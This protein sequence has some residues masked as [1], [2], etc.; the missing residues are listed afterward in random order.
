MLDQA[1]IAAIAAVVFFTALGVPRLWDRDEPRNAGCAAEML[2]RHDW[3]VPVFNAELRAHKPVLLYW[4]MMSAYATFGVTE[5]AARFWSALLGVGTALV[6]YHVGRR[7]FDE[8]VGLW[9]AVVLATTLMFGVAAR[10]ATPDSALIFFTTLAMA[11]YVFGTFPPR[12]TEADAASDTPANDVR[13]WYP[14]RWSVVALIYA[15]MGIAVLAKGPVGLVLPTASI[16]MFLLIMRLPGTREKKRWLGSSA[17]SPREAIRD[18]LGNMRAWCACVRNPKS[19]AR[20]PKQIPNSNERKPKQAALRADRVFTRRGPGFGHSSFRFLN[21][22]RISDFEI[23]I[24]LRLCRVRWV[25]YVLA[26][27]RPFAPLH[28]L[29]TCWFMRPITALAAALAVALPWYLWV[30]LRTGGAWIEEFF[31]VHNVGRAAQAMEGHDGPFF[32]YLIAICVGFFPWSIFFGPTLI[33]AAR[34]IRADHPWKPGLILLVCW[35]G[36]YVGLFSLARTKLPNYI[37]P[38]YPA[39][40]LLTGSFLYR[41]RRQPAWSPALLPKLS[42]AI[43]VLV[44]LGM[45][46]GLPLAAHLYLP[47]EEWLGLIALVPLVGGIVAL[48]LQARAKPGPVVTAVAV[49]SVLFATALVG[50]VPVRV[51]RHRTDHALLDAI[52]ARGDAPRIAALG[53]LEPSWVFYGRQPITELRR[54]DVTAAKDFLVAD[55][56]LLITTERLYDETRSELTEDAHIVAKAQRFLKKGQLVLVARDDARRVAAAHRTSAK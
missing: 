10:A 23:R 43:L 15:V 56:A 49:T 16:G 46:I 45:L 17:A 40:A 54:K 33:E 20:S 47:G 5:F 48:W 28:F 9:G 8:E 26:V 22:F 6:T 21:L 53:C 3:V 24:W 36:V 30:G 1:L 18:L 39:L 34:K 2:K 11:V 37:T 35:A 13:A 19:E 52:R 14:R 50:V 55:G 41:Y 31:L 4:L 42:L 29:R 27:L 12:R 51:D 7:L 44:G 38:A 32:Y 25:R